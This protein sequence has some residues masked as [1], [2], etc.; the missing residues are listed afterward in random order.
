MG[1]GVEINIILK[2][3]NNKAVTSKGCILRRLNAHLYEVW[4]EE[5]TTILT[6][7]TDQF[8]EINKGK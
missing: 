4:S 5:E 7:S 3:E 2:D 8:E 1:E 6:L